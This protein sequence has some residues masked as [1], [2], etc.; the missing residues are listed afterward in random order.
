MSTPFALALSL[1]LA[2]QQPAGPAPRPNPNGLPELNRVRY[3][4]L[5]PAY[6][7]R[8][9]EAFE[10]GYEETALFLS[11]YS[12]ARNSPELLFNGVCGGENYFDAA[13]AGDDMAV[14][15]DLGP[16]VPL[17]TLDQ[18]RAFNYKRVVG[19]ENESRFTQTARVVKGNT[20]VV[21]VSKDDVR[22]LFA[23]TV[24]KFEPDARVELSYV[25][26]NYSI[27]QRVEAAK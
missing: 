10:R 14:I 24:T 7:C 5:G 27:Q 16:G 3:A 12:R 25:V 2:F 23:F 18:P 11:E 4:V 13:L 19:A 17:T 22:G 15:A 9:K 8:S 21:M 1:L 26:L 20:Y 6:G